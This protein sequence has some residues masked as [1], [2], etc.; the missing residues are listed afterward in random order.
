[1]DMGET[2]D[3]LTGLGRHYG[4]QVLILGLLGQIIGHTHGV[5]RG[6]EDGVVNGVLHL[7]A[8]HIDLH[9]DLANALDILFAGH[10]CHDKNILSNFIF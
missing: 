3:A 9:R 4:H 5:Q 1:M 7:L 10:Q 2:V 8:E 6:A